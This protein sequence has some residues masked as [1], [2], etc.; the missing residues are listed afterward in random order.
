M[1][2][3]RCATDMRCTGFTFYG[4]EDD[5]SLASLCALAGSRSGTVATD[6]ADGPFSELPT[7]P[8]TGSD[9]ATRASSRVGAPP[10]VQNSL[11]YTSTQNYAIMLGLDKLT[12]GF[13]Q[14]VGTESSGNLYARQGFLHTCGLTDSDEVVI[15]TAAASRVYAVRTWKVRAGSPSPLFCPVRHVCER[16][17]SNDANHDH[18]V[19]AHA[20]YLSACSDLSTVASLTRRRPPSLTCI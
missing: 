13:Y 20:H 8:Q 10:R 16:F 3:H 2:K 5:P 4:D 15:E 14:P 19:H 6:F 18:D 17:S 12:D 1:C 7:T 9:N 11:E